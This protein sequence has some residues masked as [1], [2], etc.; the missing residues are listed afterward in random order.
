MT[1]A[2]VLDLTQ[3]IQFDEIQYSLLKVAPYT[4]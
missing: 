1:L 2:C 3:S 4:F